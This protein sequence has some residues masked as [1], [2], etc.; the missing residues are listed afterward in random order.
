MGSLE[1]IYNLLP[2]VLFAVSLC[3]VLSFLV[4]LKEVFGVKLSFKLDETKHH[5][6]MLLF[7]CVFLI[8]T[9]WLYIYIYVTVPKQMGKDYPI[10]PFLKLLP[11]FLFILNVFFTSIVKALRTNVF[12]GWHLIIALL[13]VGDLCITFGLANAKKIKFEGTEINYVFKIKEKTVNTNNHLFV[14]GETQT[15]I[16]LYNKKDSTTSV[17]K[18]SD[19]DSLV[20]KSL[21]NN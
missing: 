6:S 10:N 16:F 20:I 19:I 7:H 2:T 11:D 15:N 18:R 9:I 8:L 14:I 12:K 5:L 4:G 3:F 13:F 21:N 1:L 17:L